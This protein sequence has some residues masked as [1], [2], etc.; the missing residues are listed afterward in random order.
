MPKVPFVVMVG[1]FKPCW[2]PQYLGIT[3]DAVQRRGGGRAAAEIGV[4]HV[5]LA[6]GDSVGSIAV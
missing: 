3:V 4:R 2:P 5:G 6:A 1:V